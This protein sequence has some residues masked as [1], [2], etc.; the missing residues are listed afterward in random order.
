MDTMLKFFVRGT[1]RQILSLLLQKQPRQL[2]S[3]LDLL[4]L[5]GNSRNSSQL[6]TIFIPK[7]KKE[8]WS[9]Q[10]RELYCTL[11]QYQIGL[12]TAQNQTKFIF[13]FQSIG[14][15]AMMARSVSDEIQEQ[16]M[17]DLRDQSLPPP[18]KSDDRY[19][20]SLS[21]KVVPQSIQEKMKI[22]VAFFR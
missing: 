16:V 7:H 2:F 9:N 14:S 20:W 13:I 1:L 17:N 10:N 19:N 5:W 6:S 8:G 22:N 3:S 15:L 4:F 12:T 21:K 18:A 11:N